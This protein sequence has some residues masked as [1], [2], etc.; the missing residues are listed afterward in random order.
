[1]VDARRHFVLNRA[2]ARVGLEVHDVETVL[3]MRVTEALPSSRLVPLSMNQGRPI[4]LE[5]PSST[6][7]QPLLNL[8]AQFTGVNE[9][10]EAR[11]GRRGRRKR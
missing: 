7:S 4:V 1:M 10:A 2:D 9:L 6:V 3:S 11:R 5:D 8:A